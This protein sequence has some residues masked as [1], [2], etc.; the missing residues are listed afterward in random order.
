MSLASLIVSGLSLVTV[1]II[2]VRSV[3]LGDSPRVL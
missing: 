3:R 2:G 1:V